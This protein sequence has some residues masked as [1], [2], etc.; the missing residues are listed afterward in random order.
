MRKR[1]FVVGSASLVALMALA[2]CGGGSSAGTPASGTG[3]A[4]APANQTLVVDT[5]FNLKTVDPGRM[6]ET[7]GLLIDRALYST[8]LTFTGGDVKKPVPDLA[9]SYTASPDGTT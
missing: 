5:T 2:A 7:T 6:F 4:A 1:S 3:S 8:L 9:E